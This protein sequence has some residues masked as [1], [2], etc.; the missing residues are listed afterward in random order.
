MRLGFAL[1]GFA[2]SFGV[3][4]PVMEGACG[5]PGSSGSQFLGNTPVL[6]SAPPGNTSASQVHTALALL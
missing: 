2:S 6:A 3:V 4:I 1:R 5:V